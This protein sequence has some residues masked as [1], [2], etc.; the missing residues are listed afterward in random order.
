M[1]SQPEFQLLYWKGNFGGRGEFVRLMLSVCGASWVDTAQVRAAGA[2]HAAEQGAVNDEQA[3]SSCVLEYVR[4]EADGY[5]VLFPPILVHGERVLNQTPAILLYLGQLFG[6]APTEPLALAHAL[7]VTMHALDALAGAEKAYHPLSYSGSYESQQEPAKA[8][9]AEFLEA[10]LPVFTGVLE[11]QLASNSEGGGYYIGASMTFADIAVY[12]LVRGW[13]SSQPIHWEAS[14]A[15]H[16][17]LVG[18][19]SRMDSEARVAA[20]LASD[21]STQMED[22]RNSPLAKEPLVQVNSFM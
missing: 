8:T 3:A 20:F 21:K 15:S 10:R 22:P 17:L 7:Q 14:K 19:A 13:R 1:E 4:G 11:R 12:Q 2:N 18:F 5:P 9:I 16:P 6:L